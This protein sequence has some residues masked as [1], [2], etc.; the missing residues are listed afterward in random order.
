ML[1]ADVASVVTAVGVSLAALAI[2]QAQRQRIREFESFYVTRYWSLMDCLS[3]N[4][5][6]GAG[7]GINEQDELTIRSYLRLCEDELKLRRLGYI[8]DETWKIWA[9]GIR[10]QLERA[11]FR[12]VWMAVESE[13]DHSGNR[14]FA[15]V[16]ALQAGEMDP[17][18]IPKWRRRLRGLATSPGP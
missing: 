4:A 12:E 7:N 9:D 2:R 8:A 17:C 13:V 18:R 3:V 5:L 1:I 11:P 6:T 16:R 15:L 14:D 10:T